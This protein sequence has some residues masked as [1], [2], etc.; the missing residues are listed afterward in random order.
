MTTIGALRH[1][2]DRGLIDRRVAAVAGRN[3]MPI[4]GRVAG[5]ILRFLKE[6]GPIFARN[7][8]YLYVSVVIESARFGNMIEFDL[9]FNVP[10]P[11]KIYDVLS[12]FTCRGETFVSSIWESKASTDGPPNA[13]FEAVKRQEGRLGLMAIRAAIEDVVR[14]LDVLH[15]EAKTHTI[16][17]SG[18]HAGDNDHVHGR[19]FM[20][21]LGTLLQ[22]LALYIDDLSAYSAASK[23][24]GTDD[25][26]VASINA[27]L[28]E[29]DTSRALRWSDIDIPGPSR[30]F[31]DDSPINLRIA[32]AKA[33]GNEDLI[34]Q[35]LWEAL[36]TTFY[37]R[38]FT[39]LKEKLAPEEKLRVSAQAF[40]MAKETHDDLNAHDA[41]VFLIDQQDWEGV[42]SLWD[43][44]NERHALLLSWWSHD[45]KNDLATA[46]KLSGPLPE[47]ACSLLRMIVSRWV[48][49]DAASA[50]ARKMASIFDRSVGVCPRPAKQPTHAQFLDALRQ[51]L[52]NRTKFLSLI[53]PVPKEDATST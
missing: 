11:K 9:E 7:N 15:P 52:G 41:F 1:R 10:W 16:T 8:T 39:Q 32:V 6:R 47:I 22:W 51:K 5:G 31:D 29:G 28:K 42:S 50:Q 21:K 13:F 40:A 23:I 3:V 4:I 35:Y 33:A 19:S 36:R 24:A 44:Y 18:G 27:W 46:E 38:Y 2:I 17:L 49:K 43:R 26:R 12:I 34:R 48:D 30:A 25:P 53:S 45:E 14:H 37:T 20:R